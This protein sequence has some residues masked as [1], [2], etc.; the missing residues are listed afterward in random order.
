[1]TTAT[2]PPVD[3][4]FLHTP[5]PEEEFYTAGQKFRYLSED[6]QLSPATYLLAQTEAGTVNLIG[7]TS[8][9]RWTT[10]LI[11][12]AGRLSKSVFDAH[13]NGH[14]ATKWVLQP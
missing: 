6:G 3:V 14:N 12:N 9:N 11:A 2:L 5:E 8:G 1:M 10:S 13:F 4:A 7:L